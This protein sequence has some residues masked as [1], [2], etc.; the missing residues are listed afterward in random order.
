M[1]DL[2]KRERSSYTLSSVCSQKQELA[3]SRERKLDAPNLVL[4][5]ERPNTCN[6]SETLSTV[7]QLL[8]M[9]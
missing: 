2:V 5:Y 7:E 1:C 6:M 9:I 3:N 4:E 8:I